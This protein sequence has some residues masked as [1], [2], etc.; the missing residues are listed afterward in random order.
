MNR[1][2]ISLRE[3][4]S[5]VTEPLLP[6]RTDDLR[7][8]ES[9]RAGD[10]PLSVLWDHEN[11][12][13]ITSRSWVGV[14]QF[15]SF[16]VEVT[17]KLVGE[18]LGVLKMLDFAGGLQ[19][20]RR[21]ETTRPLAVEGRSLLDLICLLLAEE[22]ERLIHQGLLQDYLERQES[23]T[24]LRGRLDVMKQATRRFGRVDVLEC[25]FEDFETNIWE[26]Q[27]IAAAAMVASHVCRDA[28]VRS[29]VRRVASLFGE[30][31]DAYALPELGHLKAQISYHR[32]NAHYQAAHSWAMLILESAG[33]R[34]LF[35]SGAATSFAF[36]LDMNAL[37]E[38]F[39]TKLLI[40]N[41][42]S[43]ELAIR[44]QKK[45]RS[46]IFNERTGKSYAAIIPDVR[47][48]DR[49]EP[50]H[51]I[52]PLDVKYKLYDERKAD[53][54]DVYQTFFYAYAYASSEQTPLGRIAYPTAK[55]SEGFALRVK[56]ISGAR[57]GRIE[58]FGINVPAVL[59]LIESNDR[60]GLI[61][62]LS[63]L[64]A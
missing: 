4:D 31:A 48:D 33:V 38:E 14:V 50:T 39:V 58:G 47:I 61:E 34:D 40:D 24:I 6:P 21:A 28:A 44:A 36:L 43:A 64:V 27:L 15:A 62:T 57:T 54:G 16:E 10:S 52:V 51:R 42:A 37:F 63:Q 19:S 2:R 49:R 26:N 3:W 20:L 18:K 60:P 55:E 46:I 9:L 8:A 5:A 7:L 35:S 11:R 13:H 30:A 12:A 22:S 1:P 32:R 53:S 23:L 17:P 59:D 29:R 45:D 25:V 56:G 41:L